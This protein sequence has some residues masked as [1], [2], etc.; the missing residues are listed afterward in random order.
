MTS[1]QIELV[2]SSFRKVEPILHKAIIIF[3]DRLFELDRSL[4]QMFH[5]PREE[6]AR[7]LAH[8]LTV[9]VNGLSRPQQI[10]AIVEDL[11]RRH[12]TFG[13]RE[14]HYATV[15]EALLWTLQAELGDAFT[16]EVR[17]AWACAYLFLAS[18]M[19]RA[20]VGAVPQPA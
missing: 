15:G 17:E 9:V 14:Q 11:G 4:R 8:V 3:Y 10:L 1:H 2:Q 16:S 20:S 6:Q 5:S 18:A 19:Q 7:K 12:L 13:V